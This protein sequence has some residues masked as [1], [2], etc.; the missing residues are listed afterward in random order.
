VTRAETLV[1]QLE[2]LPA[3]SHI[4]PIYSSPD[5]KLRM[6]VPYFEAGMV[7]G[8]Q[9]LYIADQ[10]SRDDLR[11]HGIGS[12]E[13]VARGVFVPLTARESYLRN[14]HFDPD[15]M[16][17]FWTER[18]AAARA[19]GYLGL[20]VTGEM[21]WVFGRDIDSELFIDYEA[22]LNRFLHSTGIR[23]MCLY[24]WGRSKPSMLRDVLRTHPLAIIDLQL[25][26]NPYYEPAELVLGDGDVEGARLNRMVTQ[27]Q[28]LSRR[29]TALVDL[30]HFALEGPLADLIHAAQVLV[31]TELGVQYVQIFEVL[32]SG[33]AVRLV[34]TTGPDSAA[35]G[36]V[37][38][39]TPDNPLA[40]SS[41]GMD[42]PLI[43]SDWAHETRFKLPAALRE[44]GVISSISTT[45]GVSACG[46]LYGMLSVHCQQGR[47]FSDA[48]C[49]FLESVGISLASAIAAARSASSFR[50]LVEHAPDV[51]VRFDS[52]LRVAYVNPTI[53]RATGSPA[54]ALVG[55]TSLDL[56][57]LET[58]L[59][60]WELT[61]R[62][63]WRTRREQEFE[64]TLRTLPGERVFD[65][66]IVPEIGSDGE[67]QSLLSISRDITA[68]R[69][70]KAER[71]ELYRQLVVQQ[72]EVQELVGRLGQDRERLRSGSAAA[73]LLHLTDRERY[74]L[75]LVAAGRT[76]REIGAEIGIASGTAKNL[77]A[78]ILSK[79][80]VTNRT[81]AAVRAVELDIVESAQ[82]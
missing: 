37:E 25:L 77:V 50:A 43:I 11:A 74:I 13:D 59:A 80:N 49:L 20:R 57:V 60:A 65:S 33:G 48:E 30:G 47:I 76:N 45:I 15:Q 7:R 70:A 82:E 69:A 63:V 1:R 14:G 75:R 79:L 46:P 5:D 10:A 61:L 2:N 22:R 41:L 18:L 42:G 9:C 27:L 28:S 6:L 81:E 4:C 26:D 19:A 78:K 54:A 56:G 58:Q 40:S 36:S 23:A 62:R 12:E 55:K 24:D 72:N 67:V 52:D 16:F 71:W 34:G 39:L 44:A 38:R 53:E 73:S 68:Q 8:E 35:I 51:I 29:D 66:R 21:T 32:P 3:G 17:E 31:T 64:L